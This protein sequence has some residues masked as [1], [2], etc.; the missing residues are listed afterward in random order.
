MPSQKN[1]VAPQLDLVVSDINNI[2]NMQ[3]ANITQLNTPTF[4]NLPLFKIDANNTAYMNMGI[5]S[6]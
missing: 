3:F 6:R 4:L 2:P 5:D 1:N